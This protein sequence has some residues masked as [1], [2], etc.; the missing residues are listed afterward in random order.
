M[1]AYQKFAP[2]Y[3]A[4]MGDRKTAAEQVRRLLS[5][6]APNCKSVLELACGTGSVLK[7][8]AVVYDV[9]GLDVAPR[10]LAIARRK[11][12]TVPVYRMDMTRFRLKRKFDAVICVFDSINHLTRWS[13]WQS[14][15]TQAHAHLNDGGVFIVDV[16]TEA[17]F[18][19]LDQKPV[20]VHS[21]GENILLMDVTCNEPAL[22]RWNIKVF[23]REKHGKYVLHEEDIFEKAFPTRKIAD[24]LH[25]KFRKVRQLDL[26]R[27][28][29][30][31][32]SHRIHFV[33]I[34]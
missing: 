1:I 17:K 34:K 24:A 8:L 5:A 27:R 2:Y 4:V 3:D 10:M 14:V 16:N 18:R 32:L 11:C 15:F 21:F 12:P 26:Q 29:V 28:R 13:S 9:A 7:Q 33:C 30:S 23:A 25:T 19:A 22:S 31:P 20:W 6:Y